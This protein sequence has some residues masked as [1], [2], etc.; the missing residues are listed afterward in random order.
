MK[1]VQRYVF[2]LF[3]KKFLTIIFDLKNLFNG[4]MFFKQILLIH[5]LQ[6][7]H[8]FFVELSYYNNFLNNI[9]ILNSF[10]Y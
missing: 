9:I 3:F 4:K 6:D 7:V 1:T 5:L 2:K 8:N 10:Y